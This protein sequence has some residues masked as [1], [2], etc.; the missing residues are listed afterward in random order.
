[1]NSI[2]KTTITLLAFLSLNIAYA[3][4]EDET[5]QITKMRAASSKHPSASGEIFLKIN[6]P[7]HGCTWIKFPQTDTALLSFLLASKS[8][9]AQVKFWFA[10]D[11]CYLQTVELQ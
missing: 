5:G 8:T 2:K 7:M 1:V 6:A 9:S 11:T 3:A 4:T 10:S